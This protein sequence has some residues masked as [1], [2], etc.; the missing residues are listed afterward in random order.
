MIVEDLLVAPRAYR[1]G[2]GPSYDFRGVYHALREAALRGR[3][4]PAAQRIY[5]SRRRLKRRLGQRLANEGEIE[6]QMARRSFAVLHPEQMGFADQIRAV[7]GADV[8][9]GVDGSALHLSA[10]MRPRARMLVLET[11]RRL[12]VLHLNALMGVET[13]ALPALRPAND[14]A[15]RSIDPNQLDA[16]LDN[17]GCPPASGAVRRL[18]R[19]LFR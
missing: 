10:F 14:A 3:R 18:I 19:H 9:A 16:A 5:L 7:A 12:N 17:L 1:I 2:L 13:I 4:R 8:V 15:S 11:Q 6:R